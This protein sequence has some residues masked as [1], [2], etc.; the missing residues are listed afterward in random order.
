MSCDMTIFNVCHKAIRTRPK[1]EIWSCA[2]VLAGEQFLLDTSR[3]YHLLHII[4]L[5][6]E[7]LKS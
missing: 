6:C 4:L 5:F 7:V 3:I 1:E 2:L